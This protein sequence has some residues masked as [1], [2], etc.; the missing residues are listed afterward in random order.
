MQSGWFDQIHIYTFERKDGLPLSESDI[1]T[2]KQTAPPELD[3]WTLISGG[4]RVVTGATRDFTCS[5][6][7]GLCVN[8][9]VNKDLDSSVL[10]IRDQK[11][12][13]PQEETE[14]EAGEEDLG[15]GDEEP[16]EEN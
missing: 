3:K 16:P 1:N 5:D 10:R 13:S 2:L 12:E 15:E 7:Q 9:T 6:L 14:E 8:F 4:R 11:G